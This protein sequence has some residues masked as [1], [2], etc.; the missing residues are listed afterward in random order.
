MPSLAILQ[1][2][3]RQNMLDRGFSSLLEGEIVSDDISA[4]DRFQIYQNNFRGS[5]VEALLGVFPIVSAFVGEVFTR[6]A[7]KHFV[8]MSPPNEACLSSYGSAFSDFLKDY[9]HASDVP[10]IADLARV[11]WAVFDAQHQKEVTPT[12][13]ENQRQLNPN[14]QLLSS[15]YPL[16]NLWMVGT[17]QLMP[18]AVHLEQGGQTLCVILHEGQIELVALTEEENKAILTLPDVLAGA[19]TEI[20]KA[21]IAKNVL[22]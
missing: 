1:N 20:I 6:T 18:E 2:E 10:Y 8:E 7:I 19:D 5:L 21:L 15:D 4:A 11:E 17:G 22:V 13:K 9:E 3:M 14:V 16:L 12:V